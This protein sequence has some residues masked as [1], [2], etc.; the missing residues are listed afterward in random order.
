MAFTTNISGTVQLDD[1]K[2]LA[3]DKSFIG[4]ASQ[5][6]VFDQLAVAKTDIGAVSL[7][8]QKFKNLSGDGSLT[9]LEDAAGELLNVEPIV[10]TPKEKGNAITLTNLASI[11]TGGV[12]DLGAPSRLGQNLSTVRNTLAAKALDLGTNVM[13]VG[14]GAVA[15]IGATDVIT[16]AVLDKAF[17]KLARKNIGKI[18][19]AY[20]LVAH[21]DVIYDIRKETG[22]GSWQ[23]TSKYANA[24]E[25]MANEVGMYKG[26]RVLRNNEVTV[27]NNGTVDVYNSYVLGL[28]ALG[29]GE[30]QTPRLTLSEAATKIPGRFYHLGWYGVFDYTI[31]DGDAVLVIKS[32]GS[33]NA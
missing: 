13:V 30:S 1:A 17:T 12:I 2:I 22:D 29:Y 27:A 3:F 21:E 31:V 24:V 7:T 11:Q 14:G 9:E 28:N 5:A 32:A 8:F 25:L 16:G 6:N 20:F 10:L 23:D 26:L 18:N 4:E 15:D 19:G 33:G